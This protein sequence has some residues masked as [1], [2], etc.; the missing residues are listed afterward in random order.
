LSPV[1]FKYTKVKITLEQATKA[2]KGLALLFNIG[3]RGGVGGQRHVPVALT[4]DTQYPLNT[5]LGGSQGRS[6]QVRKTSPPSRFD[7]RTVHTV[8][9]RYTDCV[10]VCDMIYLLTAIGLSPGGSA[11]LYTNNT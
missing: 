4:P 3:A 6:G 1:V 10:C 11:H 7:L 2:Q 9:S 8:A 5:R